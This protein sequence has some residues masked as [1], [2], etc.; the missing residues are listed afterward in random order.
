MKRTLP[1][2]IVCL[3]LLAQ[4]V[5]AAT[6]IKGPKGEVLGQTSAQGP[7][8][9]PN[10]KAPQL[11]AQGPVANPQYKAPAAKTISQPKPLAKVVSP[12]VSENPVAGGGDAIVW[13]N[14]HWLESIG[15]IPL[16]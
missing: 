8:A 11:S 10:Y 15:L 9:N 16:K 6:D 14:W 2:L 4:P 5:F 7:Q 3:V 13:P 1:A 12:K